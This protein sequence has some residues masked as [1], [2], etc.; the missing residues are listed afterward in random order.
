MKP[1]DYC[2]A[3]SGIANQHMCLLSQCVEC[4][5]KDAFDIDKIK[6]ITTGDYER[7]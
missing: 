6:G 7:C 1:G 2:S 5:P 3:L 4:L